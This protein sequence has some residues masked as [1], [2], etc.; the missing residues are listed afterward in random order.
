MDK[1]KE[2]GRLIHTKRLEKRITRQELADE[3]GVTL[4]SVIGWEAGR[5]IPQDRH[6]FNIAIALKIE[7]EKMIEIKTHP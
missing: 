5:A 2:M 6:M 1:K 4:T 3:L 7:L